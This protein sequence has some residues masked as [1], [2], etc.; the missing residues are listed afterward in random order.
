MGGSGRGDGK[1]GYVSIGSK[2]WEGYGL[3]RRDGRVGYVR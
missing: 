3:G 2:W 1:V